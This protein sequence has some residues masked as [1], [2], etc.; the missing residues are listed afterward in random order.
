MKKQLFLFLCT[1]LSM[2]AGVQK[3]QAYTVENL[4]EDG[5]TLVNSESVTGVADNF[6]VLVDAYSSAYVMSAQADH[7][8]PCY[9]TINSPL[10]NPSFVWSL[11]GSDNS[12]KLKS[13]ATGAYIKQAS[14]WNTSVGYP[15]DG[16]GVVTCTFTLNGGKYDLKCIESNAMVG[17]WNDGTSGVAQDG[18]NIAANKSTAAAD[19]FFLY[20]KPKADYIAALAAAR[21]TAVA[22]A[23]QTNPVEVT[24]WI[25]N[26]DFSGDWGG[27]ECTLSS[28]GNM[29]WGQKTLESWNAGNVVV[30]QVLS[31]VPD[32]LYRLSADLISGNN[33][34]KTAYVFAV[35]AGE[36][37]SDPVSAVASAGA[38]FTVAGVWTV[39]YIRSIA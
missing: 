2:L 34:N 36:V 8:R 18:E 20:A 39:E 35:G 25:Q 4:V 10:E 27:W 7:F 3:V 38:E 9:K 24:S 31:G 15:R 23:S 26:A 6:Y 12:F 17:H 14:G 29:Q 28:S 22:E 11:E 37:K 5:W 21:Q 16:R 33:D 32:G 19:G 13:A 30:K 1:L